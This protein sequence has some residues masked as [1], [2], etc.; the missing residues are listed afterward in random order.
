[1]TYYIRSGRFGLGLL[2]RYTWVWKVVGV[3]FGFLGV[4]HTLEA[5]EIH[6][7]HITDFQQPNPFCENH[8]DGGVVD[9]DD[10]LQDG[11][12]EGE[13]NASLDGWGCTGGNCVLRLYPDL[14]S[15]SVEVPAANWP[16]PDIPPISVVS[17]DLDPGTPGD[18]VLV[19]TMGPTQ[20]CTGATVSSGPASCPHSDHT[21]EDSCEDDDYIW[22]EVEDFSDPDDREECER[23]AEGTWTDDCTLSIGSNLSASGSSWVDVPI[24]ADDCEEAQGLIVVGNFS[25]AVGDEIVFLELDDMLEA[26]GT[27]T[28]AEVCHLYHRTSATGCT[29]ITHTNLSDCEANSGSWSTPPWDTTSPPWPPQT[30]PPNCRVFKNDGTQENFTDSLSDSQLPRWRSTP[31]VAA[32]LTGDGFDELIWGS[33]KK[34]FAMKSNGALPPVFEQVKELVSTDNL[35]LCGTGGQPPQTIQC[36]RTT[37]DGGCISGHSWGVTAMVAEDFTG[38]G[39]VDLIYGSVSEVGLKML[40]HP[41]P[42]PV[43]T[44]PACLE[45]WIT[46]LDLDPRYTEPAVALPYPDGGAAFLQAGDYD[47]DG[48]LD[49]MV[50]A[51]TSL[52]VDDGG[53]DETA[54]GCRIANAPAY[55][56]LFNDGAGNFSLG[57]NGSPGQDAGDIDWLVTGDFNGDG[58]Q[59]LA[60]GDSSGPAWLDTN[61]PIEGMTYIGA[62]RSNS[63]FSVPAPAAAEDPLKFIVRAGFTRRIEGWPSPADEAATP[64]VFNAGKATLSITNSP[65]GDWTEFPDQWENIP[66]NF[67]QTE[68]TVYLTYTTFPSPGRDLSIKIELEDPTPGADTGVKL[69]SPAALDAKLVVTTATK[70]KYARGGISLAVV[71]TQTVVLGTNVQLPGHEGEFRILDTSTCASNPCLNGGTCTD[72]IPLSNHTYTCDCA[73]SYSGLHCEIPPPGETNVPSPEDVPEGAATTVTELAGTS[74]TPANEGTISARTIYYNDPLPFYDGEALNNPSLNL[75]RE[76][77]IN[78]DSAGDSANFF[79]AHADTPSEFNAQ[80]CLHRGWA[81]NNPSLVDLGSLEEACVSTWTESADVDDF[82]TASNIVP[83][84]GAMLSFTLG[85]HIALTTAYMN[86]PSRLFSPAFSP[87][88]FSGGL[89]GD[90]DYLDAFPVTGRNYSDPATNPIDTDSVVYI[91]ANDGFLH[92]FDLTLHATTKTVIGATEKWAYAPANSV[93]RIR[94]Q[95]AFFAADDDDL[96]TWSRYRYK[97]FVDGPVM[98]GDAYRS[99]D[100]SWRRVV[101]AGQGDGQSLATGP[102]TTLRR[103]FYFALD[104]TDPANPQPLWEFS[105]PMVMISNVGVACPDHTKLCSFPALGCSPEKSIPDCA[106]TVGSPDKFADALGEAHSKPVIARVKANSGNIKWVALMASGRN[107]TNFKSA[108]RSVYMLDLFTGKVLKKWTLADKLKYTDD[109]APSGYV[110][111]G[112]AVVDISDTDD[113]ECNDARDERDGC[114]GVID[115]AYVGDSRGKLWRIDLRKGY[116]DYRVKPVNIFHAKTTNEASESIDGPIGHTPAIAI[117]EGWPLVLFGTGGT[118]EADITGK[119]HFYAVWDGPPNLAATP[120]LLTNY[121]PAGEG[122]PPRERTNIENDPLPGEWFV[123]AEA[124]T[125]NNT[126]GGPVDNHRFSAEPVVASNSIVYFS[127]AQGDLDEM[128]TCLRNLGDSNLYGYAVTDFKDLNN[129]LYEPGEIIPAFTQPAVDSNP[130]VNFLGGPTVGRIQQGIIVKPGPGV[131]IEGVPRRKTE[132]ERKKL[133]PASDIFYQTA[134]SGTAA[135]NSNPAVKRMSQ[136]HPGRLPIQID[137][138]VSRWREIA[139]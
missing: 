130:I 42:L 24:Y 135:D 114:Y 99:S 71:G 98:V 104:V 50:G 15:H 76:L 133:I 126:V 88:A 91:G 34:I 103:N 23:C 108:G 11:G 121:T 29:I 89:S 37:W 118:K 111:G 70:H 59:D 109:V 38:D 53:T 101:I 136:G 31:M 25:S 72:D 75:T 48:D 112:V 4:T 32:D 120:P 116:H 138:K 105:D 64:L 85:K 119:Y 40:K 123:V 12:R 81:Q 57:S 27:N 110:Q 56:V 92:A 7:I 5:Q 131:I 84:R 49:I 1:M 52:S 69:G 51:D 132:E 117:H 73:Q 102:D 95:W 97:R 79:G 93:G 36:L 17:G 28:D 115:F 65:S 62:V 128:D 124:G 107:N 113:F 61:E 78:T 54:S 134:S 74:G 8:I 90:V 77:M 39:W 63:L 18:E 66:Y 94:N 22:C 20:V 83:S 58:Q 60:V 80:W 2:C 13:S 19:L 127:S 122:A 86:A 100:T 45:P 33:A 43:C 21:A 82:W 139:L 55:R 96:P 6:G 26:G 68:P 47:G 3:V 129:T 137:F 67:A 10:A 46:A 44:T 16:D 9:F 35:G 125:R 41:S 30:G 14:G 106:E 87:P